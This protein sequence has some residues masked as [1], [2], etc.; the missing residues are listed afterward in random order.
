MSIDWRD[1][2][3]GQW[4]LRALVLL[5]PMVALLA[6]GQAVG[7]VQAWILALVLA[8]SAGWALM[9]ESV[10]GVVVLVLVGWSWAS[11]ADRVSAFAL[12]ATAAMLVAH[13]AALV[14]G[15]GPARL[16]VRADV[17]RLWTVRGALVFPAALVAWM[18]A[19]A[20]RELPDSRNVWVLGLVIAVSV[21][22]VATVALQSL[23][24][25]TDDR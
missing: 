10:V 9:P 8:L 14:L 4:G 11:D 16:P 23:M 21:V 19:R 15:Y 17:V 6:R 5:S 22:V 18:L 20:V 2:T 24:P 12:V 3:L 25:Q 1:W 7:S 13:L